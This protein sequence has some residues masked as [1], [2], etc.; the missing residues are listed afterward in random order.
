MQNLRSS[1]FVREAEF[2]LPVQ[3]HRSFFMVK[4]SLK[5]VLD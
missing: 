3:N 5:N 4:K 2:R 1:D